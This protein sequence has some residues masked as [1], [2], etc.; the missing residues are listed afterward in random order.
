MSD[1]TIQVA[2]YDEPVHFEKNGTWNDIDNDTY[3]ASVKLKTK[4][5]ALINSVRC[6]ITLGVCYIGVTARYSKY[7]YLGRMAIH[8]QCNY[9]GFPG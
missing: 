1:K 2:M 7:C 8:Q 9:I 6:D 5:C 3:I 4:S